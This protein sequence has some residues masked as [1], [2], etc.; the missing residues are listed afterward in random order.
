MKKN[1]GTY[2]VYYRVTGGDAYFDVDVKTVS[3][4]INKKE[5]TISGIKAEAKTYDGTTTATPDY[6]GIN[7]AGCG[8]EVEDD[9]SVSA[10]VAFETAD[11]GVS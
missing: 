3:A 10:T 1:A 7:L 4:T 5:L 6:S 9:I 11:A 8:V 2:T